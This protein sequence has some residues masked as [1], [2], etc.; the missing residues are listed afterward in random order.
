MGN[1]I[2]G[3]LLL[4][5]STLYALNKQFEQGISLF[6]S[7]SLGSIRSALTVLLDKG[8]VTVTESVEHGRSKK[9]YAITDVG[10]AA[11]TEWMLT[12]ITSGN[13][14]TIALAKLYL[15]GLLPTDA[16][17][18]VLADITARIAHD[19]QQLAELAAA[20]D[21]LELPPEYREIFRY[22]RLTLDYGLMSHRAAREFF[23]RVDSSFGAAD[24]RLKKPLW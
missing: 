22:Q 24:R 18:G 4:G 13:L 10:S 9:T 17:T 21:A 2:L 23:A 20:L 3:L 6:Y 15:L 5:P 19:E 12:P 16:R 11:F 8:H 14:E 1:V 7:A